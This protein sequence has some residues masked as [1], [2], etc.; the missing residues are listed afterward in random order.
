MT[1]LFSCILFLDTA[2]CLPSNLTNKSAIQTTGSGIGT[3]INNATQYRASE[4]QCPSG[5]HAPIKYTHC[6]KQSSFFNFSEVNDCT[7]MLYA[8]HRFFNVW[9]GSTPLKWG[10]WT[11]AL[12][13]Y[14]PLTDF[15]QCIEWLNTNNE[16]TEMGQN[17]IQ[18]N[19][20]ET[21]NLCSHVIMWRLYIE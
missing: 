6:H 9:N 17:R 2:Y 20:N 21:F 8:A 18:K 10:K 13:C 14:T 19:A 5:Q 7:G 4:I 12:V 15:F 1:L 16:L 11:I 3:V